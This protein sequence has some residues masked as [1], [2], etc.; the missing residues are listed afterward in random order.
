MMK[1][2]FPSKHMVQDRRFAGP[3]WESPA[4]APVTPQE[5]H[6][7][8]TLHQL[9]ILRWKPLHSAATDG[10]VPLIVALLGDRRNDINAAS[11]DGLRP[12]HYAASAGHERAV[13]TLLA[14]ARLN[15]NLPD[16]D[17]WRALHYACAAG[18][19]SIVKMLIKDKRVDVNVTT[20]NGKYPASLAAENGYIEIAMILRDKW[21]FRVL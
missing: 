1:L 19:P 8:L 14:D 17:G 15:P 12:I 20:N 10:D 18:S 13:A 3:A 5:G 11:F 21:E 16:S 4:S 9:D 7:N 2:L 6:M